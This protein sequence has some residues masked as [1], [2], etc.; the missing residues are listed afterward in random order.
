[1]EDQLLTVH[2]ALVEAQQELESATPMG[3]YT[4][5]ITKEDRDA[6]EEVCERHGTSLAAFLRTCARV[7]PREYKT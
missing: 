3:T 5:R 4:F 7:L 1:M 2:H 6:A